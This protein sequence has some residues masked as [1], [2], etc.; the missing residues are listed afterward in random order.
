M[1]KWKEPE[2]ST[3]INELN[4][5]ME[6]AKELGN[7]LH[8]ASSPKVRQLL[9]ERILSSYDKALKM[10]QCSGDLA[11]VEFESPPNTPPSLAGSSPRSEISDRDFKDQ[12]NSYVSK[13]RKTAQQWTRRVRLCSGTGSEGPLDDGHSW[14]KYGQKDILGAKFPRGYFRCSH[15]HARG[16]LAT[17]QVQRLDEDPSVFEISY[18]GRHTCT[19]SVEK[20]FPKQTHHNFIHQEE[21]APDQSREILLNLETG[22]KFKAD[23][24]LEPGEQVLPPFSEFPSALTGLQNEEDCIFPS[25]FISPG[26]TPEFNYPLVNSFGMDYNLQGS[27]SDLTEIIS[28]PTSVTNSPVVELDFPL[29]PVELDPNFSFDSLDFCFSV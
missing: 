28:A 3:L 5:G 17:K 16:C 29:E 22:L 24:E 4:Q 19:Q 11:G 12:P 21:K 10:L 25:A 27:D 15:R 13:R 2:Q 8:P 9:V 20:Q 14:R 23:Q 7:H 6:L 1:E 26:S 18:K